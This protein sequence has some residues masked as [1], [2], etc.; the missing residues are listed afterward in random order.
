VTLDLNEIL[1]RELEEFKAFLRENEKPFDARCVPKSWTNLP[2]LEWRYHRAKDRIDKP[3]VLPAKPRV[4]PPLTRKQLRAE[5]DKALFS[6][7]KWVAEHLKP[8]EQR[9]EKLESTPVI[10]FVGLWVEGYE[11]VAGNLVQWNG[12]VWHCNAATKD[13]PGTSPSWTLAVK[14]GRDGKNGR[15][16]PAR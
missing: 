5:I 8:L 6:V 16:A 13:K 3:V 10:R 12:S 15:D 9:L 4:E 1:A 7:G 2:D 11:Y 14:A